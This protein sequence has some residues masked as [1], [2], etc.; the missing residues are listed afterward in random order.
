MAAPTINANRLLETLE[1][2]GHIGESPNGMQR[3]AFSRADVEGRRYVIDLMS[4]AGLTTRIDPAGNIIGRSEGNDASLPAIAFGSHTDT[5]PSGGKY[6]GALGTLAAIECARTIKELDMK[7]R[8]PIEVIDFTNEEGTRYHTVLF[9]SKAMTD[10]WDTSVLNAKDE[11][12]QTLGQ[13]LKDVGGDPN[14][15]EEARRQPT[16][17]CAYL[18]LHIEQGPTLYQTGIPVGVVTAITGRIGLRVMITGFANHAG[19]TPMHNRRDAL[20]AAS[21]IIQSV[22]LIPTTEEI[23][24][25]GTVGVATVVPGGENVIPGAADL[26]VEFRDS[27]M[28]RLEEAERRLTDICRD[29]AQKSGVEITVTLENKLISKPMSSRIKAILDYTT[30]RLGL[31]TSH[32][33]SGAGHDAQAMAEITESGMIF[34]PSVDGISHSP[35]EYSDTT[36]CINGANVLLNSVLAIDTNFI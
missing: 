36:A 23:C 31:K 6:D 34:V 18:E 1:T 2:L 9:G 13:R 27:D 8:H 20:L 3:L 30:E 22:N 5:V 35:K 4:Q 29:L 12:G 7:V 15:L 16:D 19:T 21:H 14:R 11:D 26:I 32:L 24:R 17:F 28:N 33:P 25:T 10:G